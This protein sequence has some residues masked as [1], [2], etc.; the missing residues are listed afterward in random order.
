MMASTTVF[1]LEPGVTAL[2]NGTRNGGYDDAVK[3]EENK[4]VASTWMP[5]QV[6][7]PFGGN[8]PIGEDAEEFVLMPSLA[9]LM[10]Q[11]I[12]DSSE[13]Y[14]YK[15]RQGGAISYST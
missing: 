13:S 12:K 10:T 1:V 15:V 2:G 9:S 6:M 5:D 8:A 14:K 4:V 7:I 11:N 3:Q